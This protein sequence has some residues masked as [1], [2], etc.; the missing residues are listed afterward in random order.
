MVHIH[1]YILYDGDIYNNMYTHAA[2]YGHLNGTG[3]I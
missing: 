2:R 3:S 1:I